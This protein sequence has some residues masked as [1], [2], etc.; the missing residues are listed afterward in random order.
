MCIGIVAVLMGLAL[1]SI[2]KSMGRARETRDLSQIRQNV[3]VVA[4]YVHEWRDIYPI[5]SSRPYTCMT[6]WSAPLITGGYLP[7]RAAADPIGWKQNEEVRFMLSMAMCYDP[8][9]MVRGNTLP[10][11]QT[12]SSPITQ[13]MVRHPAHKGLM[14]QGHH[15]REDA[16]TYFCCEG[17]P[18]TMP[19][20]MADLAVMRGN[21][22]DFSYQGP[23]VIVDDIGMPIL[24]T[25]GG[26][27]QRDR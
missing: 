11:K 15:V 18:V 7:S 25:W 16:R 20:A 24:T 26:V 4:A 3:T 8:I 27:T 1:P 6:N 5:A 14:V 17:P 22:N 23:I 13:S 2:G 10:Y 12:Q 21:R 9:F 19:A